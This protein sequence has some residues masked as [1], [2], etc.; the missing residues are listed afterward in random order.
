MSTEQKL[1]FDEIIINYYNEHGI[2]EKTVKKKLPK[3]IISVKEWRDYEIYRVY[4]GKRATKE[5]PFNSIIIEL[6]KEP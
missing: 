3:R 1:E 4:F 2:L 6:K 5:L